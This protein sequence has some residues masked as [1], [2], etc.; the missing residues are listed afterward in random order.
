MNKR[1]NLDEHYSLMSGETCYTQWIA[2]IKD[3]AGKPIKATAS[4][5]ATTSVSE[6][7]MAKYPVKFE[8]VYPACLMEPNTQ[9]H[10]AYKKMNATYIPFLS[11]K[12]GWKW[13][14]RQI[15]SLL[16][17]YPNTSKHLLSF[18][19]G[20]PYLQI[21]LKKVM[22]KHFRAFVRE[23]KTIDPKMHVSRITNFTIK[24]VDRDDYYANT[25]IERLRL[26]VLTS[27]TFGINPGFPNH[28]DDLRVT[29]S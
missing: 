14:R 1:Y 29:D 25:Q 17:E 3:D 23:I 20:D 27:S 19:L 4:L 15:L 9:E 24:K 22:G 8:G 5:Y 26:R 6:K 11:T 13:N 12:K 2:V 18:Y 21:R 10:Y 7:F 16:K 28:D